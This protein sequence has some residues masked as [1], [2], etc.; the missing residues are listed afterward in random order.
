ME[1]DSADWKEKFE[2]SNDQA[3]ENFLFHLC[4]R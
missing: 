1:K 2:A 3:M 4:L